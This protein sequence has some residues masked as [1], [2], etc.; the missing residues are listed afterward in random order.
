MKTQETKGTLSRI[1]AVKK[2]KRE[3]K[4]DVQ[5]PLPYINLG[6][7]LWA[8]SYPCPWVSSNYPPEEVEELPQCHFRIDL[9]R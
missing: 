8:P 9:D 6:F 3:R 7:P 4:A 2:E 1:I 5:M